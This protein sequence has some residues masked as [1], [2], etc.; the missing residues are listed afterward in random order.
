M[1]T[2]LIILLLIASL[3]CP[4]LLA[5]DDVTDAALPKVLIIGDSISMAITPHVARQLD[6][7]A[8]VL[9]NKGNAQHTGTGL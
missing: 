8:T 5:Q 3:L 7:M 4:G 1:K 6:G 2:L 9:H